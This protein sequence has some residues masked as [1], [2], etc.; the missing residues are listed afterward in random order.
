MSDLLRDTIETELSKPLVFHQLYS[1]APWGGSKIAAVFKRTDA[2]EICS[3]SW[4][5][6]GHPYGMNIVKSGAFKGKS[7]DE[8]LRLYGRKLVGAKAGDIS[9]FPLITKI[10]DA[11][12]SLSIQVHP[13]ETNAKLTDGE[14][15][16][17][18]WVV[19]GAEPGAKLYAGLR[20]GFDERSIRSALG[21]GDR[22]LSM[23]NSYEVKS[24]DVLFIPGGIVHVIGAGCL[25]Y[26]VQQS[27]NT[28][29]RLH[30]WN[31]ADVHHSDR[32]LHIEESLKTIRYD[33]SAQ[34]ISYLAPSDSRNHWHTVVR[35]GFFRIRDVV[36]TQKMSVNLDGTSFINFFAAEGQCTVTSGGESCLLQAGRSALVAACA[37]HVVLEPESNECKLIASSL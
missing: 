28:T 14:P 7:L 18:A 11:R 17:E 31:R 5:M 27:S 10:L 36:L 12:E 30:D 26:E 32:R 37:K 2:P 20:Q 24:G 35:S 23:L 21:D 13:D 29:Y 25:I 8:L 6:S 16:T 1:S 9:K 4:G 22:L 19:L 15:K 33:L 34:K 3:E